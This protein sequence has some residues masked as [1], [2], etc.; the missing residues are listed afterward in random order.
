MFQVPRKSRP[1]RQLLLS[2]QVPSFPRLSPDEPN[3]NPSR[4]HVVALDCSNRL[5]SRHP[6]EMLV[7]SV[8]A[9]KWHRNRNRDVLPKASRSGALIARPSRAGRKPHTGQA[10]VM[11]NVPAAFGPVSCQ[12][13]LR[14]HRSC[15]TAPLAAHGRP[16]QRLAES[17]A[18]RT[19][20][21][22]PARGGRTA[23]ELRRSLLCDVAGTRQSRRCSGS[24][25]CCRR[26]ACSVVQAAPRS[27]T[28]KAAD[29]RLLTARR[30]PRC[31][32]ASIASGLALALKHD[33]FGSIREVRCEQPLPPS[34]GRSEIGATRRR[35][36]E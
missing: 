18:S 14:G 17:E 15:S 23:R 20:F 2:T 13:Q 35:C 11:H 8:W 28:M 29:H 19:A 7:V 31:W 3:E 9:G 22:T 36:N 26:V 4:L 10:A 6:C 30:T 5:R 1:Q 34:R 24:R 12:S 33:V 27:V 25:C 32:T 16:A 21:A